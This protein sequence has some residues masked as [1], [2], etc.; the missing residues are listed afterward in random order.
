MLYLISLVC[1]LSQLEPHDHDEFV[2][3]KLGDA[4]RGWNRRK[5]TGYAHFI[6]YCCGEFPGSIVCDYRRLTKSFSNISTLGEVSRRRGTLYHNAKSGC[7]SLP[8][9]DTFVIH[10]RLGDVIKTDDCFYKQCSRYVVSTRCWETFRVKQEKTF[11]RP[12]VIMSN[13]NRRVHGSEGSNSIKYRSDLMGWL[14]T[15][16]NNTNVTLREDCQ[17]DHDFVFASHARH[18]LV[19]KGGYSYFLGETAKH[20]GSH[21]L[22]CD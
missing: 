18:L 9:P 8:D 3:Y 14:K 21:V 22:S 19:A 12:I 4:I 7:L 15:H 20:L 5:S 10:L 16:F 2:D 11:K 13:P 17:P 6:D 1:T